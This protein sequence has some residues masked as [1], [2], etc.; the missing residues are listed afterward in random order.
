[1]LEI[2]DEDGEDRQN[3]NFHRNWDIRDIVL[4]SQLMTDPI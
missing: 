3:H 4:L 2:R 1:M